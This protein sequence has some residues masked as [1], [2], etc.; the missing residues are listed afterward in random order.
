MRNEDYAKG[1]ALALVP[2]VG[3]TLMERISP[4]YAG[5]GAFA[6]ILRLNVAIGLFGG[7]LLAFQQSSCKT[8]MLERSFASRGANHL[9]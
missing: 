8:A 1:A 5:R 9:C 2:P 6:P 7:F 4:S 3:I